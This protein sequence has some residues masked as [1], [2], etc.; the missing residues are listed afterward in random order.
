MSNRNVSMTLAAICLLAIS[1]T[2]MAVEDVRVAEFYSN[3]CATRQF[4]ELIVPRGNG[5]LSGREIRLFD[6]TGALTRTLTFTADVPDASD[7]RVLIATPGLAAAANVASDSVIPN[8]DA[9]DLDVEGGAIWFGCCDAVQDIDIVLYGNYIGPVPPTGTTSVTGGYDEP[10]PTNGPSVVR[11][12]PQPDFDVAIPTPQNNSGD[13]G[14]L[15][16]TGDIDNDGDVDLVFSGGPVSL[17]GPQDSIRVFAQNALGVAQQVSAFAV[18]PIR[19]YI[20]LV[21]IDRDLDGDLDIA[22]SSVFGIDVFDNNGIGVFSLSTSLPG[23]D[24]ANLV[25]ADFDG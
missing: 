14:L 25:P 18:P 15:P 22:A 21:L 12:F 23:S 8:L 1:T 16:A 4:I 20:D 5:R 17:A 10:L 11:L 7:S 9:G 6:H 13:V 2:A 3:S 19:G 24:L